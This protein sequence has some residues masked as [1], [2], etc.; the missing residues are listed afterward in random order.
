M[1]EASA[2]VIFSQMLTP[3]GG[4]IQTFPNTSSL[5]S[6]TSS[7]SEESI[8]ARLTTHSLESR[9]CSLS[10][11]AVTFT[12]CKEP[13]STT[14]TEARRKGRFP[15]AVLW[16]LPVLLKYKSKLCCVLEFN[17]QT[18]SEVSQHKGEAVS[19]GPELGSEGKLGRLL[20]RFGFF[21]EWLKIVLYLGCDD[22]DTS[23]Q[24]A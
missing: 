14:E 6:P 1:N 18:C 4:K 20:R 12:F 19:A 5:G 24:L 13:S 21:C 2:R 15:I 9:C 7:R 16:M 11:V 22:N 8:L 3:T 23:P 10:W 17:P